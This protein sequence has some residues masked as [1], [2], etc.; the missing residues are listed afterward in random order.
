MPPSRGDEPR[1]RSS[2][3]GS[4]SGRL[5]RRARSRRHY[6]SRSDRGS[7]PS[8]SDSGRRDKKQRRRPSEKTSDDRAGSNRRDVDRDRNSSTRSR[9]DKEALRKG[10]YTERDRCDWD[11]DR[12]ER[13]RD[14]GDRTRSR[15]KGNSR[16]RERDREFVRNEKSTDRHKRSRSPH[17][18]DQRVGDRKPAS[19]GSRSRS[20]S[21]TVAM[22]KVQS[23]KRSSPLCSGSQEDPTAKPPMS[24]EELTKRARIEAFQRKQGMTIGG[25]DQK[26]TDLKGNGELA[27]K[28]ENP[29]GFDSTS[30]DEGAEG[31]PVAG[32]LNLQNLQALLALDPQLAAVALKAQIHGLHF[33][34][35]GG[36]GSLSVHDL[37]PTDSRKPWQDDALEDD[38]DDPSG[39]DGSI[40]SAIRALESNQVNEGQELGEADA[41]DEYMATI[42]QEIAE[43]AA[44]YGLV[45]L[46]DSRH[47]THGVGLSVGSMGAA[48]VVATEISLDEIEMLNKA[49]RDGARTRP[50]EKTVDHGS[51]AA[52]CKSPR[53]PSEEVEHGEKCVAGQK[54][55]GEKKAEND[56]ENATGDEADECTEENAIKEQREAGEKIGRPDGVAEDGPS[57][58]RDS[59]MTDTDEK[60]IESDEADEEMEEE[61]HRLFMEEM[62]KQQ[63]T[64]IIGQVAAQSA[65]PVENVGCTGAVQPQREVVEATDSKIANEAKNKQ[66]EAETDDGHERMFSGDEEDEGLKTNQKSSEEKKGGDSYFDLLKKVGNKKELPAVDHTKID[67]VKFNKNL[68]VQVREITLMKDHEV[69]ALRKTHGQIKVRGKNYP[70]PIRTFYQCGLPDKIL[71]VI[72]KREYE[73]PFPIQMQC[74]P[75]LMVGRDVIAIAET[76][77]GKTL[78]YVLPMI[79]HILDQATYL[80]G[81]CSPNSMLVA[82]SYLVTVTL[83]VE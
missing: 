40:V 73:A 79:R 28:G 17:R 47:E 19:E 8:S 29:P 70:R 16:S 72:E 56:S 20:V 42:E 60:L 41:L 65:D 52:P 21:P 59:E 38:D 24:E 11:R 26:E 31:E 9:G 30:R 75:T 25:E 53:Q 83:C 36:L 46:N 27:E 62:R 63:S 3:S 35:T 49:A 80:W 14:M 51:T 15:D 61:Y 77:S 7:S 69:E 18:K 43:E 13:D 50:R 57:L 4:E 54:D 2:S 32:Q 58:L 74:L 78:G 5:S 64:G 22:K 76:G 6:R 71:K 12:G 33:L 1:S 44:S 68:Y 48:Q 10:K 45:P 55:T 23:R 66:E 39:R 81:S 67:Y 34:S 82:S 37:Y